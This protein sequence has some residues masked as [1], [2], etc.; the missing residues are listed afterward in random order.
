MSLLILKFAENVILQQIQRYSA[1]SIETRHP[2]SSG[3][4]D[5]HALNCTESNSALKARRVRLGVVTKWQMHCALSP[6][7]RKIVAHELCKMLRFRSQRIDQIDYTKV[8][9]NQTETDKSESE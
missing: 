1:L 5:F 6:A 8:P 7:P 3:N 2:L 9:L 4:Y